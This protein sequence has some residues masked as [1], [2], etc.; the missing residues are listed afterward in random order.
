MVVKDI[1]YFER[2]F[3]LQVPKSSKPDLLDEDSEEEEEEEPAVKSK[4]MLS[5][6]ELGKVGTKN[7]ER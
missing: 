2:F 4:A 3:F 7:D 6:V 5:G 1:G